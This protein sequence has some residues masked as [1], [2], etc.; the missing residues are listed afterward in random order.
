MNK[1]RVMSNGIESGNLKFHQ[2]LRYSFVKSNIGGDHER[3]S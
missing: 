3:I 1:G 2:K